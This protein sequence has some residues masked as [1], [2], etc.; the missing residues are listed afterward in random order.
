M[1]VILIVAAVVSVILRD[2]EDA[3]VAAVEQGR[4]I[5]DNIRK[6]IKYILQKFFATTALS[7][8]DVAVS[9]IMSIMV[10]SGVE[11]KKWLRRHTGVEAARRR[12]AEAVAS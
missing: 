7:A 4:V 6:F 11:I 12:D 5:Y 10:F 1:V 2:Y 9:I 3:I 8:K